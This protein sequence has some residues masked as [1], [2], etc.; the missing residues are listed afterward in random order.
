[1]RLHRFP[2]KSDFTLDVIFSPESR[3]DELGELAIELSSSE[4]WPIPIERRYFRAFRVV[5][6]AA[7]DDRDRYVDRIGVRSRKRI[8]ELYSE[9]AGER[10]PK[11]ED[12]MKQYI[13]EIRKAIGKVIAELIKA[14]LIDAANADLEV[15]TTIRGRGYALGNL[16]ILVIDHNSD[17]ESDEE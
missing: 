3:P 4:R 15:I 7:I 2:G 5:L 6:Q 9:Q 12:S 16:T 8:G 1:M 14:G 10:V 13:G 11:S 17:D